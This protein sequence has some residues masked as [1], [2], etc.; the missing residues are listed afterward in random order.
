MRERNPGRLNNK[1]KAYKH[2]VHPVD[3]LAPQ[4]LE[5]LFHSNNSSQQKQL[6]MILSIGTNLSLVMV[7]VLIPSSSEGLQIP[8]LTDQTSKLYGLFPSTPRV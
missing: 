1:N 7:I 3:N 4:G 5:Q 8:L 6:V 2:P